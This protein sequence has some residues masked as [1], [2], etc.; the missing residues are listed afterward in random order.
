MIVS[1]IVAFTPMR[2]AGP[3]EDLY[4]RIEGCSPELLSLLARV[5]EP[6]FRWALYNREPL[7][8]WGIGTTT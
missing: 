3:V 1:S 8:Q 2:K 5:E 4:A 6:V 7:D